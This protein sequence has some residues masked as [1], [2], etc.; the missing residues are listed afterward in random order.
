MRVANDDRR[1]EARARAA[2]AAPT[3]PLARISGPGSI[4]R[5]GGRDQGAAYAA[6]SAAA[7]EIAERRGTQGLFRL[8]DAFNDPAI[9]GRG[10]ARTTDRVM[11]ET[12][13]LSLARLQSAIG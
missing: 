13:G 6:A 9:P 7:Y 11:R 8:Y 5:L 4:F 1:A 10:G 2:G 3:I 12:I